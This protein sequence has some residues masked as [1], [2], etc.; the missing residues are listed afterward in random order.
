MSRLTTGPAARIERSERILRKSHRRVMRRATAA[1]E[2]L[3]S[4]GPGEFRRDR[5]DVDAACRLSDQAYAT[6]RAL[7]RRVWGPWATGPFA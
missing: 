1:I 2:A 5:P 3:Q 4:I 7:R 6:A